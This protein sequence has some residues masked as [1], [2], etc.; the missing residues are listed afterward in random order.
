MFVVRYEVHY[1][2]LFRLI[3]CLQGLISANI[4][5]IEGAV[6]G[7]NLLWLHKDL[8]LWLKFH[9]GLASSRRFSFRM[10]IEKDG[11]IPQRRHST[12][13]IFKQFESQVPCLYGR[14]KKSQIVITNIADLLRCL[15]TA[16]GN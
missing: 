5:A 16:E 3:V 6:E 1:C 9:F 8:C 12:D 2:L 15:H 10:T 7:A 11:F 13:F 14:R 4:S